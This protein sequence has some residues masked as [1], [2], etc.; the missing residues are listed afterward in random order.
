MT[1]AVPAERDL[2]LRERK[3][4][5]TRRALADTALRLFLENGFDTTTV[6]HLVDAVEV[7]KRTFYANFESKEDAALAAEIELWDAYLA[8]VQARDIHGPLL[9][10]LHDAL[11]AALQR[12]G[13][14]WTR[15][16][17]PTRG[18]AARTPSLRN[19]SMLLSMSTQERLVQLLETKLGIDG[20]D[21]VRLRLLGEFCLSAWRCG[22]K[23]WVR[24]AQEP[25]V[26]S[27][28]RRKH[29]GIAALIGRVDDAFTAIP[30]SLTLAIP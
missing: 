16:F 7:S 27:S 21:D 15:R 13:D 14:E 28:T 17:L 9:A 12:L 19:H 3:K 6:D 11:T 18:L 26:P 20:R 22:A 30:D 25:D 24:G 10:A 4:L 5:R 29:G 1:T 2:P 23:N 8:E